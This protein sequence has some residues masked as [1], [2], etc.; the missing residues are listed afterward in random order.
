MLSK[1]LGK[2]QEALLK[3]RTHGK[4]FVERVIEVLQS[5]KHPLKVNFEAENPQL[6]LMVA[7]NQGIDSAIDLLE[8]D[9]Q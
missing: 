7:F 9:D 5:M 4:F 1:R 3:S 2:D 6:G 8:G